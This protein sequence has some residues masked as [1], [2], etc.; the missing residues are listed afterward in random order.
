MDK[1]NNIQVKSFEGIAFPKEVMKKIEITDNARATVLRGRSDIQNVLDRNDDR[2]IVIVGPC[3]IHDY[4]QALEYAQKLNGLR[5][6]VED[7][8]VII[9]RT[10]FE[11]P[12]TTV[13]WKGFLY[14]P[15]LDDSYGLAEGVYL[16]RKILVQIND[17]GLPTA[18]EVL[19]PIVI[20]YYSDLI[21][22]SAIGARTT[23]SQTHRELASG[24]SMPVGFKNGTEGNVDI[25]LNAIISSRAEHSFLGMDEEGRISIVNTKG[26]PYG[27]LILRGGK[28]GPNYSSIHISE[29]VNSCAKLG[30]PAN[31]IIDCSHANSGKDHTQQGRVWREVWKQI[32][33]GNEDILGLMLESNLQAGKQ[34]IAGGFG[35]LEPGVSVTDACISFNETEK[36]ILEIYKNDK[37]R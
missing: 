11:K 13:G 5:K 12:R 9:M 17:M 29:I 14:D 25:A 15:H 27:H 22:W 32:F 36:L 19:G 24:L 23:E 37:E 8:L 3:S 2:K 21:C 10:Y 30:L 4:D 26:N 7:R 33:D 28:K 34:D 20:Q 31:L 6:K 35:H 1:V 18:T 16:S